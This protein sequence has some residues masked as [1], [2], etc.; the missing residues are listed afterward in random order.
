VIFF[1]RLTNSHFTDAD[2]IKTNMFSI[3][4]NHIRGICSSAFQRLKI[5]N[6]ISKEIQINLPIK[7]ISHI[8]DKIFLRFCS[9][10]FNWYK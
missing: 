6:I 1:S 4:E 8:T 5:V 2:N 3:L 10:Y 9:M 7:I